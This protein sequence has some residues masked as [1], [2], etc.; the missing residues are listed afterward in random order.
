MPVGRRVR[1]RRRHAGQLRLRGSLER[2]VV[3]RAVDGIDAR[4]AAVDVDL[5][6]V[7]AV[8][9]TGKVVAQLGEHSE[10]EIAFGVQN[11]L[12]RAHRAGQDTAVGRDDDAS[13]AAVCAAQQGFGVRADFEHPDQGF[14]HRSAGGDH[15][16]FAHL[17][18]GLRV[19][20]DAAAHRVAAR[21]EMIRPAHDVEAR[22]FGGER[23]HGKRVGILAADQTAHG[24]EF[25]LERPESVAEPSA[26]HEP[27]AYRGDE[28][29][30][31]AEQLAVG[32]DVDLRVEHGPDRPRQLLAH[33]H[34]DVGVR[35]A[36]GGA[37]RV[38]LRARYFD[39]VPE[40]E[41][42]QLVRHR[43]GRRVVVIPDRMRRHEP[44]RETYEARALLSRLADQPAGFLRRAFTIEKHR[45]RLHGGHLDDRVVVAHGSRL[46]GSRNRLKHH[47]GWMPA[48]L[49]T[50]AYSW[51]S[52]RT[53]ILNSSGDMSMVS[54]PRPT[55][56]SRTTGSLSALRVSA[57]IL[58]TIPA[59]TPAGPHSANHSGAS[60]PLTPA[61]PVVGTSGNWPLRFAVP[62][63]GTWV[64]FIFAAS[65]NFSV[66]R[67][68]PLPTPAW[69][70]LIA[71]GLAFAAFTTSIR[72]L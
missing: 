69:P 51:T 38:D 45:S 9:M 23:K 65:T 16:G 56:R 24:P 33:S 46:P 4:C 13:S 63:N 54:L 71:P 14:V 66:L 39:C 27:L 22:A 59:G 17:C 25:R 47:C 48:A 58:F 43:A 7:G 49:I 21:R 72:V 68:V 18:E 20:R 19:D 8:V 67:C 31:L 55:S 15:E 40:Q 10:L 50:R 28:L 61:S 41:H 52:L 26:V 29:L 1:D 44:F 11:S 37:E 60:A 34:D 2:G 64:T 35:R 62:L 42:G 12:L 30:V 57:E 32:P 6:N 53:N 36:R 70:Q 5:E 3:A